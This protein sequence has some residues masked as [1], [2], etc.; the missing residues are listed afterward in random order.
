MLFR[1]EEAVEHPAIRILNSHRIMSIS[2]VRPDGWPQTTVVGY[3]SRGFDVFFLIFRASQKFA[4]IQH[5]N[6]VSI[7]V[8]AE[9]LELDQLT[10][11]FA[12]GQAEEITDD[13]K[14]D[15]AWR[16][17]MMRHSNLGG[18]KIPH[19]PEAAFMRVR[20]KY[21]S[22]LDFTQGLG[23]REELIV[24]D[25]GAPMDVG[26]AKDS[27]GMATGAGPGRP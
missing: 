4:N 24:D 21:V 14:R 16:L 5:D 25:H 27:W 9:P 6:R 1:A 8:A 19:A 23:H 20:C 18:F 10:A 13:Q 11:V 15:E 2:T 7:A 3:A 22:V 12:G 26:S 17:L